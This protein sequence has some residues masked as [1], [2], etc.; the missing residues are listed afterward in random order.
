MYD[1]AT[2]LNQVDLFVSVDTA[3]AHLA[4][5]MG[6]KTVCLMPHNFEDYRWGYEGK[7]KLYE[8]MKIMRLDIL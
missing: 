6:V 7:T 8:S 4:G 1:T 5:S 3:Q 2:F